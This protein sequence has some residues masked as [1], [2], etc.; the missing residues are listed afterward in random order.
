METKD[1]LDFYYKNF[2]KKTGWEEVIADDFR[3]VGGDMTKQEPIVGKQ[4]Y[5]EVIKRFGRTFT[6][7]RVKQVFASSDGAFVLANYDFKFPSGVSINGNVAELWTVKDGKLGSLT[8][9]FDT[10]NFQVFMKG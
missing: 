3:F 9:F 5:I 2:A 1:L 8:I 7:M 6:D 10:A 4:A